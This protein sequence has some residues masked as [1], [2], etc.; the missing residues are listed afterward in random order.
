MKKYCICQEFKYRLSF[1]FA[2]IFIYP[3][4]DFKITIPATNAFIR[5][6]IGKIVQCIRCNK[7][8]KLDN[9]A[10]KAEVFV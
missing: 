4:H 8:D 9:F 2:A 7:S 1:N 10:I 5:Y 6:Y 3:V